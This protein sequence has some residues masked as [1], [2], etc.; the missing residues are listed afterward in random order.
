MMIIGQLA[1][2]SNLYHRVYILVQLIHTMS[3]FFLQTRAHEQSYLIGELESLGFHSMRLN[4]L[5]DNGELRNLI[6]GI[7]ESLLQQYDQGYK[8]HPKR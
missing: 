6:E 2:A 5:N 1:Y 7:K 4:E 3:K 8:E